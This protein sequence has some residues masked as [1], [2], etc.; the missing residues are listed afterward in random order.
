MANADVMIGKDGS[1]YIDAS[2][3]VDRSNRYAKQL[4]SANPK[5]QN[6][7]LASQVRGLLDPEKGSSVFALI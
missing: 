7:Q 4:D 3:I 6:E 1:S 5:E 2:S